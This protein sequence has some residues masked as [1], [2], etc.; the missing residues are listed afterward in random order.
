MIRMLRAFSVVLAVALGVRNECYRAYKVDIIDKYEQVQPKLETLA[1]AYPA[2]PVYAQV[3]RWIQLRFHEYWIELEHTISY[4]EPPRFSAL[5]EA[6]R[7]RQWMRPAIP[8]T[9]LAT[10]KKPRNTGD[11]TDKPGKDKAADAAKNKTDDSYVANTNKVQK[12]ID[13]GEAVG[14]IATFLKAAGKDGKSAPVPNTASGNEMCLAWHI[15]DGCYSN[16]QRLKSNSTA[17][18]SLTDLDVETLC[19]F[20][21]AGMEKSKKDKE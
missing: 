9:Y 21:D 10:P 19:Q 12:L 4:V 8:A 2:E 6:I 5:F 18:G 13:R 20:I 15:K 16:C 17:H 7:Y 3:L 1:D 14:K 11:K